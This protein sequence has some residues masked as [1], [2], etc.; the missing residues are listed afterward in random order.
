MQKTLF[1]I[2]SDAEARQDEQIVT[3]LSQEFS[4]GFPWFNKQEQ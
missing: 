2:L 3:S 1:A 4:A